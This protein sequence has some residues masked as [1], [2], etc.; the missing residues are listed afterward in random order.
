M[1][2]MGFM[3]DQKYCIGCQTCQHACRARH[4]VEPGTYPRKATSSQIQVVGPFLS[5]ACNHCTAPACVVVCPVGALTKREDDGIVVHDPEI[6]IGCLSCQ[7]ACP[8]DHPQLNTITGKM[9]K[10]D[11]C[12]ALQDKGETPACVEACPVKVL[13]VGTIEDLE[14]QGGVKE[15]VDFTYAETEPNFRFIPID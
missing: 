4:G 12:A 14:A 15:G 5:M 3:L 8:Y 7:Q 10:C 9:V 11:M 2:Q 1:T 6:C 13:T